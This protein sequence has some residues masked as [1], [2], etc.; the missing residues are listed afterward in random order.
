MLGCME[1]K[2]E[3]LMKGEMEE[4]DKRKGSI[5]NTGRK[6]GALLKKTEV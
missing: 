5:T 6:K 4:E 1:G 2:G 3:S